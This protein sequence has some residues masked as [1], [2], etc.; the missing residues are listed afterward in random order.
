MCNDNLTKE[1]ISLYLYEKG[2]KL[3]MSENLY[4]SNFIQLIDS[5]NINF[6]RIH[7]ST[8][9]RVM[10]IHLIEMPLD[11]NRKDYLENFR[12][13]LDGKLQETYT[14]LIEDNQTGDDPFTLFL[15]RNVKLMQK[16]RKS[17]K[18]LVFENNLL[19]KVNVSIN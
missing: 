6:F 13:Y 3:A 12:E 2:R 5:F 17:V 16:K 9:T 15:D 18:P 8:E 7:Y 1:I 4:V 10:S 19:Y 11:Q 14:R